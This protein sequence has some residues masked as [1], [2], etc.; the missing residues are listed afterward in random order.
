MSVPPNQ[1][2]PSEKD[3]EPIEE[4]RNFIRIFLK[5]LWQLKTLCDEFQTFDAAYRAG[6][7]GS[8]ERQKNYDMARALTK[9]LA[10]EHH[11]LNSTVIGAWNTWQHR[12]DQKRS[13]AFFYT[14]LTDVMNKWTNTAPH[15]FCQSL[16]DYFLTNQAKKLVEF[17]I[18]DKTA[19]EAQK[20]LEYIKSLER[21][22]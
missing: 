21:L 12:D 1:A 2:G 14:F 4:D 13:N 8:E 16:N 17:M 20:L 11:N 18:D 15:I 7:D 3:Q 10:N 9:K 22:Q 6:K 5:N 19:S